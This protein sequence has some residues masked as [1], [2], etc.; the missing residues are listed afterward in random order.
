MDI[1][2]K[3]DP[4]TMHTAAG[5]PELKTINS[6]YKFNADEK[7]RL[8]SLASRM[9]EI[10]QLPIQKKKAELWKAHN[11]LKTNEPLVFIDPENGWNECIS[12]DTLTCK[13]PLARVWE[14]H[15]L[16]QIY[17][18]EV[19][20]DDRVI[21]NNF[22]VPFSFSTTGWGVDVVKVGGDHGGAYKM[23]QAIEDYEEDLPNI[24]YP[25]IIIDKPESDQ[26]MELA[27][28]IFD[29]IL[30]VRRKHNW[31]WTLGMTWEFINL[32]GLEELMMDTILEPEGVHALMNLLCEG[33]LKRLDFLQQND[34][35]SSNTGNTYVGSGGFGFTDHLA[36][37]QNISKVTTMDMWGFV[38]SQETSS[39][40][41]D[42][43]AEFV[44]PYH[45]KITERFGLNCYG[46]CEASDVRWKYVKQL[47]R[48][49]RVSFS[50]WA[51]WSK[52]EQLFGMNY[53]T[54]L[55]PM[56]SYLATAN[57]DEDVVR[58]DL[59]RALDATKNCV[60]E[61]IMK[62]NNTLGNCPR[63]ASRWV[64]MAREEIAR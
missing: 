2:N 32:R 17:W 4:A 14:M 27:L 53:I 62:D 55:K 64:E 18:F 20:K 47:P 40:S 56:P 21:D 30:N 12:A 3:V 43:Y 38:E 16:K 48:L 44:L 7:E 35:L 23:K 50:P 41:P 33:Q 57:M 15:F 6:S 46:C 24:H 11:D 36:D 61:I 5:I 1:L 59:R 29:D 58:K 13:D 8:R 26:V 19:M 22:D 60:P 31:W 49:R 45:K 63:N 37:P 42:S 28:S 54:S 34:L 39:I 51:D 25:E 10:A 52:A 9:A